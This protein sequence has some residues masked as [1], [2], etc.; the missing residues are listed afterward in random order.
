MPGGGGSIARGSLSDESIQK[1][2]SELDLDG[3]GTISE[4]EMAAVFGQL[5]LPFSRADFEHVLAE[6]DADGDGVLSLSEFASL[7]RAGSTKRRELFDTIDTDA[8]GV[9]SPQEIRDAFAPYFANRCDLQAFVEHLMHSDLDKDGAISFEEFERWAAFRRAN[10]LSAIL[11]Q[12]RCYQ[13]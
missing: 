6:H 8:D 12:V 10:S 4:H 11:D 1:I 7:I 13:P 9:W 5:H 3:S 2:F